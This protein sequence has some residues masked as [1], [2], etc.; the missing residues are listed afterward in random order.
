[1][2]NFNLDLRF[3]AYSRCYPHGDDSHLW[4]PAHGY[5]LTTI[6]VDAVGLP[7]FSATAIERG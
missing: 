4:E 2:E 5:D 7:D 1:M 3:P 6:K